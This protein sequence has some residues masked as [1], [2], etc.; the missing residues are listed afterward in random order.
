MGS[1]S[2]LA[3]S[4]WTLANQLVPSENS[5]V[6]GSDARQAELQMGT[7][8]ADGVSEWDCGVLQSLCW[9]LKVALDIPHC[10][11]WS[12]LAVKVME[13]GDGRSQHHG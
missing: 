9:R 8:Y 11:L 1:R 2:Q 13:Y 10:L 6:R 3:L 12:S 5:D 4:G 7:D